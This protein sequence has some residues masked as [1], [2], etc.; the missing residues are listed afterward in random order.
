[1]PGRPSTLAYGR[2]GTCCVCSR[3]GG[4]LFYFILFFI[5]LFIFFISSILSSF[6]NVSS[7][8]SRLDILKYCGLGCYNPTAVVSYYWGRARYR[9]PMGGGRLKGFTIQTS[10]WVPISFLI[11][12]YIKSSVRIM[13]SQLNQSISAKQKVKS[14]TVMKQRKTTL[15]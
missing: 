5:Y 9:L 1:M 14:I 2:A 15:G 3:C 12:K 8:R 13:A 11:Q 10:P 6:S 4:G 7:L